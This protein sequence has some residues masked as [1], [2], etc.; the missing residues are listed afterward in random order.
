VAQPPRPDRA[1]D[2]ITVVGAEGVLGAGAN[3]AQAQ[4]LVCER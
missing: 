2:A 4:Y 1:S 3:A